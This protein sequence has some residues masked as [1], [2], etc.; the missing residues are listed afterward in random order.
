LRV[1]R[2]LPVLLFG[3]SLA[4]R[5]ESSIWPNAVVRVERQLKSD[6]VGQRR[7]AAQRIASLGQGAGRRLALAA[8][9]DP[10]AEVRLAAQAAARQLGERGASAKVI[11]WLTDS[12]QRLRVAATELLAWSPHPRAITAL[13]RALSDPDPVVRGLAASA[14]GASGEADAVL[15]LLGHLD[16]STPQVRRDVVLSLARLSDPRAVVPLIGKIQD[17]RPEVRHAVAF[18]LG[19]FGDSRAASA[20]V[21]AL[22][23][24]DDSVRIAALDALGQL[25]DPQS[26]VAIENVA[27]ADDVPGPVRAAALSSLARLGTSHAI[28]RVV[29]TLGTDDSDAPALKALV[30]AGKKARPRLTSCVKTETN[31][32]IAD[33]CAMALGEVGDK[34]AAPLVRDALRRGAVS[35]S[36][37]LSALGTLAE[38]AYLP[39]VLEYLEAK[40]VTVRRAAVSAAAQMMHPAAPDGRAVEPIERALTRSKPGTSEFV[41]LLQLLGRSGSPRAAKILVPFAENSDLLAVRVAAIEALGH[42][43]GAGA[44]RAL[45]TALDAEEG[46]VRMAAG[47][48][49][50]RSGSGAT[51][52]ALLDRLE[53]AAEQDR[54]AVSLSLSGALSR[55][56]DSQDLERAARM[57]AASRGGTRDALI[58]AIARHPAPAALSHLRKLAQTSVD[59]ADR[60]KVAECL[61]ARNDGHALLASLAE[62]ADG[63]VRANAL[64]SLGHVGRKADAQLLATAIADKDAAAAGNAATALGRLAARHKSA[65]SLSGALCGALVS[66]R[67]AV[68]AGALSA[69]HIARL[70][71]GDEERRL[72][73]HD[74]SEAVRAA[75]ARVLVGGKGKEPLRDK[76]ALAHCAAEEVSSAVAVRCVAKPE[77]LPKHT[78]AVGVF[79]V[80]MGEA[81]PVPHSAFALQFADGSVR[82]GRSDRRGQVLELHAPRGEL[83]LIA[84][85]DILR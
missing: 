46:S 9:N 71:C 4:P 63:A 50:W 69:L 38:P 56:K 36:A 51:A 52:R 7:R 19:E 23:D 64:W 20:L 42:T 44:D 1:R 33:G 85:D 49:L 83:R 15:P 76:R 8:M 84:V 57:L 59:S 74:E 53:R 30:S 14:L 32:R 35:A 25:A 13:G 55:S 18:A 11:P 78:E 39:S 65:A 67:S 37:G 81:S 73:A 75:A 10:D 29:A 72:L 68:R 17:S 47:I 2:W 45:L 60:A 43:S 24:G 21:L 41:A 27:A 77:A 79:V 26:A 61:A 40:D 22:R 54:V 12:D 16:D 6:D 3:L 80:P 31:Q 66:S 34:S 58:E 28:D 62:D 5:A 70:R 48:A 82:L